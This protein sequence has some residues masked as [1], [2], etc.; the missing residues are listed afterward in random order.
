MDTF[1]NMRIDNR[2]PDSATLPNNT[3]H[4]G[5][6]TW[7]CMQVR[8]RAGGRTHAR[9]RVCACTHVHFLYAR[10]LDPEDLCAALPTKELTRLIHVPHVYT[11]AQTHV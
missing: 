3:T 6:L 11:H 8:G 1:T 2:I 10:R 4:K 5:I 7:A 9:R